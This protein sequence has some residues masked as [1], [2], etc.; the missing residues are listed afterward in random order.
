MS[1]QPAPPQTNQSNVLSII[2]IVCGVVAVLFFPIVFGPLG[3][4]LG[5]I[6][7][8]RGEKLSTIALVVAAVGMVVG[9]LLGALV[10]SSTQ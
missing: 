6:G 2:G 7:K 10:Y 5:G 1:Y 4:I 8:S 3:L 9:F